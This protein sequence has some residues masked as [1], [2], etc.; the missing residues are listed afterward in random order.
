MS[1]TCPRTF[2][3]LNCAYEDK[4]R[5]LYVIVMLLY[6]IICNEYL[7]VAGVACK[8]PYLELHVILI[9]L[10]ILLNTDMGWKGIK[11]NRRGKSDNFKPL[12]FT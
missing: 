1:A 9:K 8:V 7:N 12:S 5:T 10:V 6:C 4:T 3:P 2:H 11:E